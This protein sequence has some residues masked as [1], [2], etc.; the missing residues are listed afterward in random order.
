MGS[1]ERGTEAFGDIRRVG[2]MNYCCAAL[3]GLA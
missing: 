1:T 2:W 3:Q